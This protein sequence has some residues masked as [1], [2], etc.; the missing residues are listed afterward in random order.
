MG[1]AL[2]TSTAAVV[3][4]L[5][6]PATSDACTRSVCRPLF[7]VCTNGDL[8][9]TV[10][11]G[12]DGPVLGQAPIAADGTWSVTFRVP[13]GI[14]FATYLLDAAVLDANGAV[15]NGLLARAAVAVGPPPAPSPAAPVAAPVDPVAGDEPPEA[16]HA[17]PTDAL[18]A[19]STPAAARTEPIV[20]HA[21]PPAS[22]RVSAPEQPAATPAPSPGEQAGVA[23]RARPVA[24]KQV[25]ARRAQEAGT[26]PIVAPLLR[27][28]ASLSPRRAAAPGR[29]HT[30]W[31]LFAALLLLVGGGSAAAGV[32][33]HRRRPGPPVDAVELELQALL[34][35]EHAAQIRALDRE[36]EEILAGACEP[37][38][39]SSPG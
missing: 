9:A 10:T 3:T 8:Q 25:R 12:A 26:P 31:W 28:D 18:M 2:A 32:A 15:V 5:R 27:A 19:T 17:P 22:P 11:W 36:L 14:P 1:L 4:A 38:A 7:S 37:L 16:L 34:A 33:A 6:L 30:A 23:A 29:S 35:G 24:Q 20:R 13:E 21:S 39:P